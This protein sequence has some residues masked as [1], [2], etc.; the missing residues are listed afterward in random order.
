MK[1][2]IPVSSRH[3]GRTLVSNKNSHIFKVIRNIFGK[4]I[5]NYDVTNSFSMHVFG[6]KTYLATRFFY[7]S[8][9]FFFK[10]TVEDLP[11]SGTV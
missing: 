11:S 10:F 5:Q 6:G 2:S 1:C 8:F 9:S 7:F 4:Y 3:V